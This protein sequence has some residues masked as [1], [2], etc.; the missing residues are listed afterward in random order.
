M[1]TT[2]SFGTY[3]PEI[4][5]PN[6]LRLWCNV[7][8]CLGRREQIGKLDNDKNCQPIRTPTLEPR[9]NQRC[10][11]A[12]H[13]CNAVCHIMGRELWSNC[14]LAFQNVDISCQICHQ[15]LSLAWNTAGVTGVAGCTDRGATVKASIAPLCWCRTVMLQPKLRCP[16]KKC[17]CGPNSHKQKWHACFTIW[18]ILARRW[19]ASPP[20]PKP[21]AISASL[22]R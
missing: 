11:L 20:R 13:A 3:R 5:E 16:G 7:W 19:S 9:A 17:Q 21:L 10:M 22:S 15:P 14:F 18:T 8:W 2:Y 12:M 6:G 1:G 4:P